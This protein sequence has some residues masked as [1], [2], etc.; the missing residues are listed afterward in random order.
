VYRE[1]SAE[2]RAFVP[3]RY[4]SCDSR[5]DIVDEISLMAFGLD[6]FDL[7]RVL[8]VVWRRWRSGR[9]R[10]RTERRDS[11]SRERYLMSY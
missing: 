5:Y 6:G 10:R 1:K 11:E 2:A 3:V 8:R 9:R 4:W 7:V